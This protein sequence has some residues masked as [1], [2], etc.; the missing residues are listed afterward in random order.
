MLYAPT[1]T[2]DA[3][4]RSETG[5][6]EGR[7]TNGRFIAGAT[8][9]PRGRPRVANE[10]RELA[11]EHGPAAIIRLV[12]LMKS[13]DGPTAIAA[14]RELLNR[15]FGKP[16]Q[17][18]NLPSGG[19]LVTVNIGAGPIRTADELQAIY[20]EFMRNPSLDV[21][22]LRIAIP[23]ESEPVSTVEKSEED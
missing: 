19:S 1:M 14:C 17:S 3:V 6:A 23:S 4:I 11:R 18:I 2:E 21:S 8:G 12:E 10:V 15:G 5:I 7:E 13:E 9:N 16:E 20:T 22:R